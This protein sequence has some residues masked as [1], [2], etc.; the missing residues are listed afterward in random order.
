MAQPGYV[1]EL[2]TKAGFR[3]PDLR[4]YEEQARFPSVEA[5]LKTEIDGWVLKGRVDVD[6]LLPIAREKL[7]PYVG[8]GWNLAIPVAGHVITCSKH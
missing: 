7:K 8:A 6:A 1:P 4:T 3:S 2:L 5:F